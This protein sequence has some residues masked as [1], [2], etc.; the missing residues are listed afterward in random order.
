MTGGKTGTGGASDE[1]ET[2]WAAGGGITHEGNEENVSCG[3][4]KK[5]RIVGGSVARPEEFPWQVSFRLRKGNLTSGIFC[6]GSLINKKWVVTA[7]HCFDNIPEQVV[8]FIMLGEFDA[9]NKEGN[10]VVVEIKGVRITV[11]H[12]ILLFK[13]PIFYLPISRNQN[14]AWDSSI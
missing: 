6:G 7:A 4:G 9:R 11:K 12:T 13:R 5:P 10:E 2:I 3:I 8:P 14:W 1:E